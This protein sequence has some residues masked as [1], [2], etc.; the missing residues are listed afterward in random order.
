[1][2][3]TSKLFLLKL[4]ITVFPFLL[5]MNSLHEYFFNI[6][7]VL[8]E[9][10][11]LEQFLVVCYYQTGAQ[12]EIFQGRGG[13]V[14]FG[15]FN[16]Y[17]VKNTRKKSLARKDFCFFLPDI[18]KTTIWM[19]NTKKDTIRTFFPKSDS[20]LFSKRTGEAS[21]PSCAPAKSVWNKTFAFQWAA[22]F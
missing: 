7:S 19:E 4:N 10:L 6:F 20:F 21:L 8:S 22:C 15:H 13:L 16:K 2:V 12:P 18:L 1:M 9:Q 11:R 17:F 5:K 3:L 14:E